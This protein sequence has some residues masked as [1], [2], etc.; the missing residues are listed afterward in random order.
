MTNYK[1]MYYTLFNALSKA[2]ENIDVANYGA[3]RVILIEAQQKAE[4]IY[5]EAEEEAPE[6]E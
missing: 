6:T 2:I 4:E 1:K 5:I 3:A